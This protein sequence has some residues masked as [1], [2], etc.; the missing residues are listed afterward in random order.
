MDQIEKIQILLEK[1]NVMKKRVR[2]IERCPFIPDSLKPAKVAELEA[3]IGDAQAF[4]AL[5]MGMSLEEL[6]AQPSSKTPLR[7]V[8]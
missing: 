6:Q 1:I 8:S 4:A 3:C 2:A 7:L 5:F